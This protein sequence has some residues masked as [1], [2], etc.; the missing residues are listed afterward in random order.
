M[1]ETSPANVSSAQEYLRQLLADEQQLHES[2]D[3]ATVDRSTEEAASLKAVL[4]QKWLEK[5]YVW[6]RS[7]DGLSLGHYVTWLTVDSTTQLSSPVVYQPKWTV[8][9][10][11]VALFPDT[12]V[13]QVGRRRGGYQQ[14][15]KVYVPFA[16]VV[17]LRKLSSMEA[18]IHQMYLRLVEQIPPLIALAPKVPPTKAMPIPHRP[19]FGRTHRHIAGSG[20]GVPVGPLRPTRSWTA[21]RPDGPLHGDVGLQRSSQDCD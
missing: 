8:G 18:Q 12:Q 2:I 19:A 7:L 15:G 21:G 13:V 14:M 1:D 4:R 5:Q 11:V 20:S 17:M 16:R 10:F 9:G 6:V 3:R